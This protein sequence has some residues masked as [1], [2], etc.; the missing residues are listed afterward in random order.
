MHKQIYVQFISGMKCRSLSPLS[1]GDLES[2]GW[3]AGFNMPGIQV[4]I[5]LGHSP[6]FLGFDPSPSVIYKDSQSPEVGH[7]VGVLSRAP[8]VLPVS[9]LGTRS[10]GAGCHTHHGILKRLSCFGARGQRLS[11]GGAEEVWLFCV[12]AQGPPVYTSFGYQ[13]DPTHPIEGEEA[14]L[15]CFDTVHAFILWDFSMDFSFYG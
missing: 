10:W 9:F 12:T 5:F 15:A 7:G 13:P 2:R 3:V 1:I 6:L 8:P 4:S 11:L 14:A